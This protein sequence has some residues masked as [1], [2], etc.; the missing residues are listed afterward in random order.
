MNSDDPT[1]R[2]SDRADNYARYRPGYP[3]SVIDTLCDDYGLSSASVV[4]DVGSGTGI[5][6]QLLLPVAGRVYAVEPNQAM[7]QEAEGALAGHPNFVSIDARSEATTLADDSVDLITVAQAFHWFEPVATRVEFQ[8]VLQPGG[9]VALVW[10]ERDYRNDPLM[11]DYEAVLADFD[12]GYLTVRHRSHSGDLGRFFEGPFQRHLFTYSRP[13]T[14]EALWGGFLSASY[15][16]K[17][18]D[19]IYEPMRERLCGVFEAHR[20]GDEVHFVYQTVLNVGSI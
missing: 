13:L 11:R 14:F 2:F 18:G 12:L 7:R 8:R 17:P 1:V 6:T 15:A 16:P 19:P 9:W 5:L 20:Q 4:A 3:Q 10:N